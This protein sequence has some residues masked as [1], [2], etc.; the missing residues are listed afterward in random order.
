MTRNH[1]P[2]HT[3]GRR[4]DRAGRVGS[5]IQEGISGLL[6]TALNDPR[7]KT[8]TVTGVDMSPD[9]KSA[10]V[11]VVVSDGCVSQQEA[12]AGFQ[13]AK[14][15][16]KFTLAQNL[17]LRYM[18]EFHFYYDGSIDYGFHIDSVLKSIANETRPDPSPPETK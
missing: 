1:R 15:F 18:P 7:L 4:C 11:Y 2:P 10:K 14:G 17:K 6:K 9:L 12:L 8:A 13:K 3:S 16:I 5:L